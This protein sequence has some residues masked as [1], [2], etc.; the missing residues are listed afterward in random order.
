[1]EYPLSFLR[2]YNINSRPIG[3]KD[4]KYI[5]GKFSWSTIAKASF[6]IRGSE[7]PET[8]TW[9]HYI[10]VTLLYFSKNTD[11]SHPEYARKAVDKDLAFVCRPD[12]KIFFYIS[13]CLVNYCC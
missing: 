8:V 9:E 10:L 4:G 6:R 12:R 2:Y 1:M 11:V 7:N 3:E 5:F 13:T